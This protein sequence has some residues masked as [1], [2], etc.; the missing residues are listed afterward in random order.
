[1][2]RLRDLGFAI[3]EFPPGPSNAINDVVGV[4]VGHRTVIRDE[5]DVARTGITIVNNR[6]VGERNDLCYAGISPQIRRRVNAGC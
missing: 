1:M 2:T 3:G 4:T 6:S 5:P